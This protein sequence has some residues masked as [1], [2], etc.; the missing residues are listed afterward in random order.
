MLLELQNEKLNVTKKSHKEKLMRICC[1]KQTICKILIIVYSGDSK[2]GL[3]LA[4]RNV[5]IL[6]EQSF[7]QL[8]NLF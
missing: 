7:P 3:S 6:A 2:Q 1:F 4:P 5:N 8:K